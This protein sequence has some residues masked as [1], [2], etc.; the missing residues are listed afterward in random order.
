MTK[1][2]IE[3]DKYNRPAA[4]CNLEEFDPI[5]ANE[6]DFV[7]VCEWMNGEGFDI[8]INDDHYSFTRGELDAINYLVKYLNEN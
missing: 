7:E 8:S 4:C 2:K 6:S 3:V 5:F 1:K